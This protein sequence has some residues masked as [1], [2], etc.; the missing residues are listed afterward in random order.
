MG[1][2]RAHVAIAYQLG[3]ASAGVA[4]VPAVIGVVAGRGGAEAI[5]ACLFVATVALVATHVAAGRLSGDLLH[6][7]AV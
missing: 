2:A 6:A 1:T 7:R 3:A 5:G 4:A